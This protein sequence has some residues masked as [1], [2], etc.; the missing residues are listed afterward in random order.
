MNPNIDESQIISNLILHFLHSYKW[1]SFT[2]FLFYLLH[3]S[4]F[5]L[6]LA[7]PFTLGST[8]SFSIW[9]ALSHPRG[10]NSSPQVIV[11]FPVLNLFIS[12][13]FRLPH[14]KLELTL[15]KDQFF[16]LSFWIPHLSDT[17]L[18]FPAFLAQEYDP[19]SSHD[20]RKDMP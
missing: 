16:P 4:L 8:A 3:F 20:L 1:F 17:P 2:F 9:V 13:V 5:K 18:V 10:P 15:P 19:G 6:K 7:L 11:S 12:Y 14:G